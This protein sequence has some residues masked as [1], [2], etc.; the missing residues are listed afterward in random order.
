MII[1]AIKR[2]RFRELSVPEVETVRLLNHL[3]I[4]VDDMGD[5]RAWLTL[6]MRVV[7]SPA[8]V[9]SLSI[10]YWDL[11][12]RLTLIFD[13]LPMKFGSRDMETARSLE[14]AEHWEKLGVWMA[15]AWRFVPNWPTE[16]PI[17]R[18]I[19]QVTLTL[20]LQH[21]SALPRFEGLSDSVSSWD[22]HLALRNICA[23]AGAEQLPLEPP[24]L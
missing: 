19:E 9:E 23:Q 24:L 1:H 3:N 4:D 10:H 6:L 11:L 20:L 16:N 17:V 5:K 21:P 18:E 22:L 15:I 8:G 13:H 14:E 7:H 2:I 12:D